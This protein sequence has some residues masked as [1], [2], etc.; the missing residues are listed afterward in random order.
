MNLISVI[1]PVYNSEKYLYRCIES[2]TAQTYKNLEIILVDDGSTDNSGTICDDF[3]EKDER[4]KIIHK[5]NG[6]VSSARN[7]GLKSFTGDYLTFIDSDDYVDENYIEILYNNMSEGIDIVISMFKH[8]NSDLKLEKTVN[9]C[10]EKQIVYIDNNF[11]FNEKK[12]NYT[13]WGKLFKRSLL[14]GLYFS[15]TIYFGEDSLFCASAMIKSSSVKYIPD[16]CY[17]YVEYEES[18]SHGSL[19]QKKLTSIKAWEGIYKLFPIDS[20]SYKT[21]TEN[22]LNLCFH[23]YGKLLTDSG[24]N[25]LI[26]DIYS[27]IVSNDTK[28][29]IKSINTSFKV[30]M[31]YYLL[32][33]CRKIYDIVLILKEPFV[34]HYK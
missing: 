15:E 24:S 19:S 6:G 18:L 25:R 7:T 16:C 14:K 17:N 20:V 3:A 28:E 27:L 31:K 12:V 9:Y 33:K 22:Y 1:V 10:C 4:V 32:I 29:F 21:S 11:D 23:I 5:E 13:V 34:K 8:L 30:K 2:I 26:D